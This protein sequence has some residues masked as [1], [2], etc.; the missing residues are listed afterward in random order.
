MNE[1]LKQ[2]NREGSKLV[3]ASTLFLWVLLCLM[4]K[5]SFQEWNSKVDLNSPGPVH[6][7]CE[8]PYTQLCTVIRRWQKLVGWDWGFLLFLHASMATSIW[9]NRTR[10]G[11]FFFLSSQMNTA[12]SRKF[13]SYYTNFQKNTSVLKISHNCTSVTQASVYP[14][15]LARIYPSL[16]LFN[17]I[18]EIFT[19]CCWHQ[20]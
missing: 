17:F 9:I 16:Y 12:Y 8:L 20:R 13:K 14:Y 1:T 18:P 15:L 6:W 7:G 3:N 10:K 19:D 4:F 11:H 2:Q 5:N